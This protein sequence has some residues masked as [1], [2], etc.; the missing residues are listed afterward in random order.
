MKPSLNQPR[1]GMNI[2]YITGSAKSGK[3]AALEAIYKS[4]PKESTIY[5]RGDST[6]AGFVQLGQMSQRSIKTVLIDDFDPLGNIPLGKLAM[7]PEFSDATVY[8][9]LASDKPDPS[10]LIDTYLRVMKMVEEA[11]PTV[12]RAIRERLHEINPINISIKPSHL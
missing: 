2:I 8:V 11:D 6:M 7:I 3:S 12:S 10:V 1:K 5:S 4:L 9:A